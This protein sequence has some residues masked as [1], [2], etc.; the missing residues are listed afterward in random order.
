MALIIETGEGKADAQSYVSVVDA[1]AYHVSMGNTQWSD[2]PDL[3]ESCLVKA[4]QM[5][6]IVWGKKYLSRKC[7]KPQRLLFP[8]LGFY[9]NNGDYIDYNEIPTPLKD[10][11]CELALLY[12]SSGT[13]LLAVDDTAGIKRKTQK[14]GDLEETVEYTGTQTVKNT[15]DKYSKVD[16]ILTSLISQP[17]FTLV[18]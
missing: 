4:T 13:D 5:V 9:D 3:Q 6:D 8:R 14:V 1:T 18:L 12:M 7:S 16:M 10:A 2:R 11:T 15:Q 17:C